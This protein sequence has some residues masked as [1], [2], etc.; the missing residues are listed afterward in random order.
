MLAL[1]TL[2]LPLTQDPEPAGVRAALESGLVELQN[3]EAQW[4]ER[5]TA[6]D[7]S[8][9]ELFGYDP[10]GHALGLATLASFLH[11][12][13]GR[14]E[15]AV[16]AAQLLA[17][18]GA[19]RDDV[20]DELRHARVEYADGLPPVPNF[21]HVG[22]FAEAWDRVRGCAAI[23]DA[24]RA[25]VVELVAGAA[26]HV[27]TF[28]E[29]GPHNRALL[30]AEGLA[31]CARAT[32]E[33]PRAGDWGRMAAILA[34]DSRAAWEIEDASLYHPI[35][36]LAG[37]R[38][39][40]ATGDASF[41][42]WPQTRFYL[43][44]FLE[45][46]T[47]AG[48]L[49]AFGDAWWGS[50]TWR[51][52]LCLARGAGVLQDPELAW[53]AARLADA[54]ALDPA[55]TSA[56]KI[57]VQLDG[58]PAAPAPRAPDPR[59]R[60]ALDDVLAKK[61]VWRDSWSPDSMY[62]CLNYRDE[63]D[64]GRLHRD[65]LRDTLAV[66]E[67][68]MHHGHADE[69]AVVLW[70]DEGAV[71]LHDAGYRDVA[72]SGPHGAWRADVFHNRLVGRPRV[73]TEGE[74]L[75]DVLLD[76]G[77]YRPTR[78]ERLDELD[79][80]GVRYARVRVDE[81]QRGWVTDRVLLYLEEARTLVVVDSVEV[82]RPGEFTFV[83]LWATGELVA[84]D[85][86]AYRAIGTVELPHTRELALDLRG[87]AAVETFPLSRHRG[88]ETVLGNPAAGPRAA[89][90]RVNF[91]SLLASVAPDEAPALALT[92]VADEG[93]HVSLVL[94]GADGARVEIL[95]A[96]DLDRGRREAD[97]RP[98]VDPAAARIESARLATDGDLALLRTS[99][100]AGTRWDVVGATFLEVDGAAVFSARPFQVFQTNGRSDVVGRARWRRWWGTVR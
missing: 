83:P 49:P 87:G 25:E 77:A 50:S 71:L 80:D 84:R 21:F 68:K 36:L 100:G 54:M 30:R 7:S 74:S 98:R 91:V 4:R 94:A 9:A 73:A 51:A 3:R 58:V 56:A 12:K 45:L 34:E 57:A 67:E 38:Y 55:T 17:R 39:A 10:P 63:G 5:M 47:P 18:M 62:L 88:D 20:P 48:H 69:G 19:Y 35:W 37:M 11:A 93:A 85:R 33:H 72:P 1:L 26:D 8:W 99:P 23:D 60:F 16:L 92:S 43:R 31:W 75:E 27:F 44:Y 79:L 61:I 13:S 64:W 76:D 52:H 2:L 42:R 6:R 32:P 22:E 15:D 46:L 95:L 97:V 70:M 59:A 90:E 96:L 24:L 81:L 89:G 86:G 66:V 82:T 41:W 40:D 29:W 65:Y 14:D 28:P 78:T 53:G